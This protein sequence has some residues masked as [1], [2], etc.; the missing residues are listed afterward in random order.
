M[1]ETPAEREPS[2]AEQEWQQRKDNREQTCR[3]KTAKGNSYR[4]PLTA[5]CVAARMQDQCDQT[6]EAY[7]CTVCS[8]WHV[9][10]PGH[11]FRK[12]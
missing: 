11:G 9:G 7:R 6:I 4:Y 12:A 8:N 10:R 1:P 2:Q 3:D 5:K